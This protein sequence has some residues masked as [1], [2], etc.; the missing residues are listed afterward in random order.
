MRKLVLSLMQ[1]TIFIASEPIKSNSLEH[2]DTA[3]HT[4]IKLHRIHFLTF[5][6]VQANSYGFVVIFILH[7][8][9]LSGIDGS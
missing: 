2:S 3:E 5:I 9:K 7:K 6:L 8:P 1:S 4:F